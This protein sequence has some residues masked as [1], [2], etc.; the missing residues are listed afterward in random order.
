MNDMFTELFS[1]PILN[2]NADIL[3]IVFSFLLAAFLTLGLSFVYSI[4]NKKREGNHIMMQ[5]LIVLSVTIAGAMA[6]VGNELARAFGLVG[7]V[8][9]IRFRT[10]VQNYRDMAF[11]FIAIVIGMACGLR[12]YAVAGIVDAIAGGLLLVFS[13]V[14]FGEKRGSKHCYEF[15]VEFEDGNIDR[16]K[17]EDA[18]ASHGLAFE[19]S[20]VKL[21]LARNQYEYNIFT[22]DKAKIEGLI[23]GFRTDFAGQNVTLK[24]S[25]VER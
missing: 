1:K 18:L 24:L 16:K 11:V 23:E 5:S 9:V 17:I 25:V 10:S 13:L 7:A 6:I 21:E 4:V 14:R 2:E 19:M 8:S 20:S 22:E 3:S 15:R 12:L